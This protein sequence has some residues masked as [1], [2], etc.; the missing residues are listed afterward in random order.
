MIRALV[1][2]V[3]VGCARP[4]PPPA[5]ADDPLAQPVDA[6]LAGEA[7]AV[8]YSGYRRGQRPGRGDEAALPTREQVEEDLRLLSRELRLIRLYD[9]GAHAEQVLE[10]I[11]TEGLPLRVVLGAWLDAELSNHEGCEWLTEPIPAARLAENALANEAEVE[12]AI[13]LAGR[14]PGIVAA[15]SVGNEALVTWNDHLVPVERVVALMGRAREATGLPV[16]T[17][18]NYVPW[19]EHAALLGPAADFAFI[20]TYPQWEGRDVDEALAYTVENLARVR[21]ALPDEPLAIGEAGW[22]S[23]ASEFPDRADEARQARYVGELVGWARA[24]RVTTFLF[25]AFDEPWKG[26]PADPDGAEKHWGLFDV[27]RRPKAVVGEVFPALLG[28]PDAP[29]ETS[30]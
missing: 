27:D 19:A 21:A 1:A 7:V 23:V 3:L 5:P 11:A 20:H 26:D 2:L 29:P 18:D 22:A 28:P 15:L 12:R 4:A 14:Y 13:A 25:E 30:P 24:H 9:A 17:A 10:V 8:A 6:L 16:T